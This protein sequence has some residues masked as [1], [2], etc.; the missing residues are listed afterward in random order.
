MPRINQLHYCHNSVLGEYYTYKVRAVNSVG[1]SDYSD[2]FT[3]QAGTN[4][5]A[6]LNVRT[7]LDADQENLIIAWDPAPCDNGLKIQGY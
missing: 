6:P 5:C 2:S 4:P 7:R 1:A 3:Q